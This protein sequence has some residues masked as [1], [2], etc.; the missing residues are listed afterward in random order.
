[1]CLLKEWFY[2]V[3]SCKNFATSRENCATSRKNFATSRKPIFKTYFFRMSHPAE[4]RVF[5]KIVEYRTHVGNYT[6]LS[7]PHPAFFCGLCHYLP[8]NPS[9]SGIFRWKSVKRYYF[10]WEK[11]SFAV[12]SDS[13]VWC[14]RLDE[15]T[16]TLRNEYSWNN[17]STS[18]RANRAWFAHR[19]GRIWSCWL[20]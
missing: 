9:K 5:Y 17:G 4:R 16:Q 1:M 7:S 2:K 12:T 13:V 18:G 14:A 19:C 6:I 11:C 8:Q 10:S 20:T 15:A 3:K